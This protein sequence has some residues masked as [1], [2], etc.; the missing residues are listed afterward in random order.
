VFNYEYRF[1]LLGYL[2]YAYFILQ[3]DFKKTSGFVKQKILHVIGTFSLF[4]LNVTSFRYLYHLIVNFQDYYQRSKPT[5]LGTA[6]PELNIFI[7][8]ISNILGVVILASV[9]GLLNR[10]NSAR[11]LT[12]RIIPYAV[13][14]SLPG[15][16]DLYL[17]QS[18]ILVQILAIVLIVFFILIHIVLFLIYNSKKMSEFFVSKKE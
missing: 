9:F 8:L 10:R 16:Y 14:T 15:L 13:L 12:I 6:A 17:R 2:V 7:I 4:L 5:W 1:F 3:K 11:K 18:E